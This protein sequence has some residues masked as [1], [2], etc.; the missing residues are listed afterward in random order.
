MT[1]LRNNNTLLTT[2]TSIHTFDVHAFAEGERDPEERKIFFKPLER[3]MSYDW[4][5]MCTYYTNID[6]VNETVED[7]KIQAK[8]ERKRERE[9][10]EYKFERRKNRVET[11]DSAQLVR[12]DIPAELL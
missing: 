11:F 8:S 3:T 10:E 2:Y 6:N 9:Q 12:A 5:N 7:R 4:Q 1:K